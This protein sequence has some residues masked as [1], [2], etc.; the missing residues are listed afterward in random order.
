V[1]R[2]KIVTVLGANGAG[3]STILKTISG[4]I[5]P[6]KGQIRFNGAES[7][8]RPDRIVRMGIGH[9]PEGREVSAA[10]GVEEPQDGRLHALRPGRR[11]GTSSWSVRLLSDPE[12]APGQEAGLPGGS[13]RCWRSAA[14]CCPGRR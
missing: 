9:A 3:K 5:D 10:V 14:R 6:S 11:R 4:I 2:G 12:G 1:P 13:S 7:R 8:A